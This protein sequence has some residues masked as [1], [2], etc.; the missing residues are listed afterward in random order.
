[1][2]EVIVISLGIV[3]LILYFCYAI[4]RRSFETITIYDYEAALLYKKGCFQKKLEP[5]QHSYY[6]SNTE[7]YKEDTRL[8]TMIAAGQEVLTKDNINIKISISMTWFLQ[9]YLKAYKTSQNHHSDLYSQFQMVIRQAIEDQEL[10]S[11]L[12]NRNIVA[13]KTMELLRPFATEIGIEIKTIA[14]RDIM[15]PAVLKKAYSGALE[16]RKD[17]ER[18][19]ERARGEQAIFRK[20]ANL[21]KMLSD[22]PS[23]L[24]LRTLQAF[25]ESQ[26]VSVFLGD[27]LSTKI[28]ENNGTKK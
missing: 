9:D 6:V 25:S 22:N 8:S 20:L 3:G 16:A 15:L 27:T 23:L 1:M 14:L 4:W 24:Q 11:I 13:E 18:E 17:I 2:P 28:S 19:I 21:S 12:E 26:N 10:D 5:G 7:I